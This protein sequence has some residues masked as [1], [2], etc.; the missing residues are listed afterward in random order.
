MGDGDSD[1]SDFFSFLDEV[2]VS[3]VWDDKGTF[4]IIAYAEDEFGLFGPEVSKTIVI[5]SY[6]MV[7]NLLLRFFESHPLFFKILQ[8]LFQIIY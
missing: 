8:I 4:V 3:H 6:K 7:N 1:T 5:S 2:M